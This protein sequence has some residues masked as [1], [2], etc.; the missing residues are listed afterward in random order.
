MAEA[1]IEIKAGGTEFSASGDQQWVTEQL[2]K[3][4][5]NVSKLASTRPTSESDTPGET[6]RGSGKPDGAEGRK[7]LATHLKDKSARQIK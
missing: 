5:A 7:S 4:F 3:F 2:D 1:K 6:A